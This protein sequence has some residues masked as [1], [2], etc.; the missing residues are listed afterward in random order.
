MCGPPLTSKDSPK[1]T[2]SERRAKTAKNASKPERKLL[3]DTEGPDPHTPL[4]FVVFKVGQVVGSHGRGGTLKVRIYSD[5]PEHLLTIDAFTLGN[6]PKP[7]AVTGSQLHAGQLLLSLDGI[8]TPEDAAPFV[9]LPV[10]IP[11]AKLPPL[12]PGD[13]F[14]YQLLGLKVAT[15]EGMPL[16]VV[17]DIIETG[18]NDVLVVDPGTGA[19]DLLL[20]MIPTVILDIDPAGGRIVARPLT[21][22]GDP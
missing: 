4:E 15:E 18:A 13:Y 10:T 1:R 3:V 14:I 6:E 11:A 5:D 7:R 17:T 12:A 8:T 21:F 2:R 16:G 22:Y 9:N 20:P 19:A